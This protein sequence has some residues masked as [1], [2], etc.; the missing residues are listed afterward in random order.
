MFLSEIEK[1]SNKRG[2]K[3]LIKLETTSTQNQAFDGVSKKLG[4]D[5]PSWG[6][7]AREDGRNF[8]VALG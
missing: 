1:P 6:T 5:H 4:S 7:E 8:I 2:F 3:M